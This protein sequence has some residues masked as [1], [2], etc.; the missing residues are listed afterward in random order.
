MLAI[1]ARLCLFHPRAYEARVPPEQRTGLSECR[2][3]GGAFDH[4]FTQT[5]LAK[6]AS[7]S[8]SLVAEVSSLC[9]SSVCLITLDFPPKRETARCE[10][11][12]KSNSKSMSFCPAC[13]WAMVLRVSCFG[14]FLQ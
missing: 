5:P 13:F 14:P 4:E 2:Q 1:D 3:S 12:A 11:S 8:G 9:I 10:Q 6:H 7:F